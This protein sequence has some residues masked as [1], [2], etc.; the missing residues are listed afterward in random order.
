MPVSTQRSPVKLSQYVFPKKTLYLRG[1]GSTILASKNVVVAN[2]EVL[3]GAALAN[4]DCAW[5]CVFVTG[6]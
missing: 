4:M 2:A 6:S 1:V 3:P 5:L